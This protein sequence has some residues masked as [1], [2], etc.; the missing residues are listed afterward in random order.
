ML[1]LYEKGGFVLNNLFFYLQRSKDLYENHYALVC[2]TEK[3]TYGELYKAAL[4]ISREIM[5][6]GALKEPVFIYLPKTEKAI[7]SMMGI[8]ASG[9]FYTPTD[10]KFPLEKP[11]RIY[12]QLNSKVTI[13]DTKNYS[14]CIEIGI[15]EETIINIDDIDLFA[16]CDE[17]YIVNSCTEDLA[18]VLF[19]SGSTGVP[20]G[21]TIKRG[22]VVD[23]I[24]WAAECFDI[25]ENDSICNQAPFYFD[26]STLDIY[27]MLSRGA[28]LHIVPESFYAFPAKLGQYLVDNKITTIFW[29]PSVFQIFQKLDLLSKF[30]GICL[31]KILFAG[32]VMHNKELNYWRSKLPN[33][34]YANLYGPTEITV[35]CTYYIVDREYSDDEPLPIG[36]ARKN[37]EVILLDSNNCEVDEPDVQ[38]ELC[39]KGYSLS[40]GYW[41]DEEKTQRAFVQNPLNNMYREIIY[42]TGD[43][44]HYNE[45]KLIMFDGRIDNQI[46]HKGCRIELGEIENMSMGLD[47]IQQVC[48][49]YNADDDTLNFFTVIDGEVDEKTIAKDL[50]AILPNYMFP[51]KVILLKDFPLNDNGKYD[52]KKLKTML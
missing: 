45:E 25:N 52:R 26:N 32:E 35:D 10:V 31:S 46:K 15:P 28:T 50:K 30:E 3:V 9:N 40:Y 27:L 16:D 37:M 6:K 5:N 33:A 19:T 39:V 36:V 13:T 42:R 34:L 38:G 20:K 21:V 49:V 14:R 4:N 24:E 22:A 47:Y 7:I 18:Y 29:V 44:A 12:E 23:Y 43:I 41:K 1:K 17:K 2:G 11:K 8:L 48:V 51:D